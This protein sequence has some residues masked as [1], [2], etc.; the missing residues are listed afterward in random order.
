MSGMI[1]VALGAAGADAGGACFWVDAHA[2]HLRQV[3]DQ[4]AVDT[5]E[6]RPVMAAAANGDGDAI[7]ASKIDGGNH[8]GHVDTARDGERPFVDHS[9]IQGACLVIAW[10]A[11]FD[12]C[13]PK[14]NFEASELCSFLCSFLHGSL[15]QALIVA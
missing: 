1:N 7:V 14:P 10:I 15:P 2:L 8:V 5:A 13:P 4:P 11:R 6:A 3:K 9:V 12:E